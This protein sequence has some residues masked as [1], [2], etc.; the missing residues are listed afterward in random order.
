MI[1][2]ILIFGI[3]CFNWLALTAQTTFNI[4]QAIDYAYNNNTEIKN[5]MLN[6]SDAEQ[7]ILERRAIGLPQVNGKIEFQHFIQ[8]PQVALPE[9]FFIDP[10][11][12]QVPEGI[13][14]RASFQLKNNFTPSITAS[15]L[16]F[17]GSY[18]TG[19]KAAR[20]YKNFVQKQLD[21]KKSEVRDQ[22]TGAY[23]PLL[24]IDQSIKLIDQNTSN[25]QQLITETKALY[26]EGFVEQLDV[27]R[28]ELS[29]ANLAAER[30]NL[31]RQRET[32]ANALKFVIGFPKEDELILSETIESLL[33][34]GDT[35]YNTET[36]EITNKHQYQVAALN[37]QLNEL[38]VELNQR[39]YLPNLA[40]FASYN[41]QFLG[42]NF[43]DGFW[44]P[45]F[46]VGAT[47]N[48]PIFD[49]FE[50]RSKVERAKIQ[51]LMAQNQQ[52]MLAE[53]IFLDIKNT[54]IAFENAM[55]RV[56][57]REKNVALAQRIYDTTKIKYK[58]GVG[59]SLEL[60][61]AEQ[62]LFSAQNNYTQAVYDAI[63]AKMD[64]DSALGD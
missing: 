23:L 22:V 16:L 28:L 30:E 13:D 27:D 43:K 20:L 61:Q 2:N 31:V 54:Q 63:V 46:V 15:S 42:D 39:G 19:L 26:K 57:D 51:L 18:L 11:T 4:Q 53:S 50:K 14:R 35:T 58:E 8:V 47:I 36:F 10:M 45:S 29:N 52:E 1:K 3:C 49:G 12:G 7:Q 60:S 9:A 33:E 24:L 38:N 32:V 55:N 56:R 5:A 62:A 44:A 40:A 59:S 64:L 48:V 6:I 25:L 41:Y 17:D 21:T 34:V 37:S